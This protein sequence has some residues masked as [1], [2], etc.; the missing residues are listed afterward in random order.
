MHY[1]FILL[2][3]T[4]LQF[5]SVRTQFIKIKPII[6]LT[7]FDVKFPTPPLPRTKFKPVALNWT[8]RRCEESSLRRISIFLFSFALF[9]TFHVF[10]FCQGIHHYFE[11][12]VARWESKM[13]RELWNFVL[14]LETDESPVTLACVMD[15]S[16]SHLLL[17]LYYRHEGVLAILVTDR[18]GVPLVKG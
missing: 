15:T 18:D 10:Y 7:N 2:N 1:S 3:F 16:F 4:A 8:W 5:F 13:R 12:L 6:C 14:T 11:D 17:C 9:I